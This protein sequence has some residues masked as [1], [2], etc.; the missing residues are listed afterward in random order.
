MK[1]E[2]TAAL[3]PSPNPQ[4]LLSGGLHLKG[5]VIASRTE[6]KEWEKEKYTQTTLEVSDGEQVYTF[7]HKHGAEPFKAPAPFAQVIV[8]VEYAASDKGRITV[9]G[10]LL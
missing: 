9:R 4:P 7:K 2:N 8:R 5:T 3:P 1:T 6:E 10:R